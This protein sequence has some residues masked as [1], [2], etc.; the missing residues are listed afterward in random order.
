MTKPEKSLEGKQS[1]FFFGKN[2]AKNHA[3]KDPNAELTLEEEDCVQEFKAF[4]RGGNYSINL[5][6]RVWPSIMQEYCVPEKQLDRL[7]DK[8]GL[9]IKLGRI[10]SYK[11]EEDV[12]QWHE[13]HT[14]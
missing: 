3:K 2:H 14:I 6:N 1:R 13:Q 9:W 8:A 5:L 11:H 12:P 10:R 7:L 4:A